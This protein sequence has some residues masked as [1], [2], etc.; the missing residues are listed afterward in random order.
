MDE[1]TLREPWSRRRLITVLVLVAGVAL[2]LVTGLVYASITALR[3]RPAVTA[4]GAV[5]RGSETSGR[6][7]GRAYRDALAAQPMLATITDDM[8]PTGPALAKPGQMVAPPS[9][10]TGPA[11][12]PS[13]FPHTPAGAVG[14]LAAIDITTLTPMSVGFARD[15]HQGWAMAG[16]RFDRWEIA[17]SIRDFHASAGTV[18]GDAGVT[19]SATAVGAQIKGVDGPDWVLACVQLDINAVVVEQVRFGYGH[20]ERMQWH[21]AKWMIGPGR[22]PSPAPSTWPGSQRSLDAGWQ[23]WVDASPGAR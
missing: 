12:V 13:G 10:G 11:G 20:C 8:T 5:A 16:A 23:L 7:S 1:P 6:A 18:D 21:G 19:L 9:D 17:R 22:P 15:V 14:Q 4:D 2:L 3:P